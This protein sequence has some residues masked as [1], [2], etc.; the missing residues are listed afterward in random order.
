MCNLKSKIYF[1]SI[2][3]MLLLPDIVLAA[4]SG[5]GSGGGNSQGLG[6]IANSIT[7]IMSDFVKLIF[8]IAAVAGSG[9]LLVSF[10][11]FKQHKDSPQQISL[12]QPIALLLIG[13]GL[14]WLPFIA[15]ETGKTVGA[16]NSGIASPSGN[17]PGFFGSGN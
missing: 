16:N 4:A 12:G 6:Q 8:A 1:V 14:I 7:G 9:F 11:K 2:I 3:I 15:Q 13:I 10:F 17:L 5:S